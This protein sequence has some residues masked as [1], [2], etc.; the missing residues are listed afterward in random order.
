MILTTKGRFAVMAL[1]DIAIN[2]NG[3]PVNLAD[4]AR[5]QG[6]DT[7]YLE[8]IFIKLKKSGIVQSFRGPGGGYKLARQS[9]DLII[10]DILRAVEEGIK[11]TRC[12]P[13][14]GEGCMKDKSVCLTHHLWEELEDTIH[15]YL[16]NITIA[17]VCENNLKIGQRCNVV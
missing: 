9:N 1:V 2:C 16:K 12:T 8:Q 17:A 15:G 10:S 3:N 4:I 7:G 14:T 11:M 13:N 5:R 6:I